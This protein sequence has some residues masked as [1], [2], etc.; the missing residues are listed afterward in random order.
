MALADLKAVIESDTNIPANLQ[1]LFHNSLPL[2][3]PSKTLSAVGISEGDII[4]MQ[5]R[6]VQAPGAD[7]QPQRAEPSR[8]RDDAEILR[9]QALGNPVVM[10]QLRQHRPELASAA[11]SPNQFRE[12]WDNLRRQ[13]ESAEEEKELMIAK[14]NADPFD[15]EAQAKIEEM[16]RENGVMQN[17][18][19]AMENTPEAFGRV[20]MLYI[21]VEVNNRKVKAFVDSG[22]QAT[23]MSPDCARECGIMRLLDKRFAG[24]ARGVGTAKILGR[25]HAAQIKIGSLYLSCSFTVMEGKD[26]DLLLGLDMLKR[27]QACIDLRKNALIIMNDEV[28]FL[29]EADIPKGEI[30]LGDEPTI[31]GPGGIQVGGRSGAIM[32]PETEQSSASGQGKGKAAEVSSSQGPSAQ[33]STGAYP[34]AHVAQ[35]MDLG[36]SREEV[37]EALQMAGGNL[38]VAAGI[39]YQ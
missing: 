9:L 39:L 16:I 13:Q 18:T 12:V 6:R 1:V 38:E 31:K 21:P 26:V 32:P 34:A 37:L 36:F 14:L 35:L 25:V 11:Q 2:P 28:P 5:V 3:D 27:H 15:V 19:Q 8:V 20:H 23:I 30:L 24:I 22:A 29:G 33:Q 17:L 7:R 4:I 10:E